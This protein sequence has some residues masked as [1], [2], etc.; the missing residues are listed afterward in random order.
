MRLLLL[1]ISLAVLSPLSWA[2]Q[3]QEKHVILLLWRGITDAEQGFM[4]YLS[5]RENV[6]FTILDANR[7]KLK[8]AEYIDSLRYKDADLIYSFGTTITLNLL[9]TYEAPSDFRLNNSTPVV[10]SIVT[11]PIG[12]KLIP[13]I[14][15]NARNFTGVS[16]IV[17]H[18]IQFK[19][20]EKL[21][22]I[23]KIGVIYNPDENNSVLTAN[24][25]MELSESYNKRV[26]LYPLEVNKNKS[27]SSLI[28]KTVSQMKSDGVDLAYLPPDSYI[29][30]KGGEVVT[31]L[32]DMDIPTFSATE[33]P[34][35][36]HE[37]LFGIVSRYYNVGQFAAHKA[38]LILKGTSKAN[39]VAMESLSQ[40]SYIVNIKAAK[41][42]DYYPPVSILK[43]SE[44][45]GNS[46][47]V[48]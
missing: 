26:I 10:F 48:R 43:I 19:A 41:K 42:L 44:V 22:N 39:D 28:N 37:A 35:R 12:S 45:I 27:N 30:A 20:I 3:S 6:R 38:E 11:D 5:Q 21:N 15:S 13:D 4:N 33:S 32:H 17:P 25:M 14:N 18:E 40:Y 34:I 31:A 23:S 1:I 46:N 7:D 36:T 8:L 9:G 24:K 29:I 47:D 16:H 2:T